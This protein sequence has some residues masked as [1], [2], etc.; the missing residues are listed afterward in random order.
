VGASSRIQISPSVKAAMQLAV[1]FPGQGSQYPG[2]ADPWLEHKAGR[3]TL[4]RASKAL[5]WDVVETSRD[6]EALK[7][8]DIVQPAIFA[9]DVAAYDVLR[10]EGVTFHVAAG[11]S[12]GEYAALVAAGVMDMRR[13]LQA[14]AVRA[15]AMQKASEE[16]PGAMTALLGLS[17]DEAREV[18]EVAGRGDVLAVANENGAKQIVLSGSVAAV[19]R[20]EELARGRGGRTVRLQVAGAFHSPLMESAVQPVREAISRIDFHAPQFPVVSNAS[21]KATT[22]PM[23]LRDLLGRHLISPVRWELS[24]RAM[25]DMGIQGFVE[26]G[27]GDVLGKLAR[28]AVPGSEVRSI[29]SPADART[30]AEELRRPTAAIQGRD[31]GK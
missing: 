20:A 4:A 29:G 17:L 11:H 30:F 6:P 21:G 28:R 2:M 7:R 16:N 9:C 23:V 31:S 19:E 13:G 12:L 22:Q 8:T 15:S 5:G 24:L 14:L 26:A 3:K 25:A 10:A 1:L 27:P 18:C